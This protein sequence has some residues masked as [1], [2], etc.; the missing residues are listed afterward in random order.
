M[1]DALSEFSDSYWRAAL[2]D[3]GRTWPFDRLSPCV[4]GF[5]DPAR[6]ARIAKARLKYAPYDLLTERPLLL[7]KLTRRGKDD[8]V[9]ALGFIGFLV[10]SRTRYIL[11]TNKNLYCEGHHAVSLAECRGLG[12]RS[13]SA[14]H[15]QSVTLSFPDNTVE[16]ELADVIAGSNI[17][18]E[19]F[20]FTDFLHRILEKR[21]DAPAGEMTAL[22]HPW[23]GNRFVDELKKLGVIHK[24]LV[25]ASRPAFADERII[26]RLADFIV[27]NRRVLFKDGHWLLSGDA[28]FT[29]RD[30]YEGASPAHAH[31]IHSH[32]PVLNVLSVPAAILASKYNEEQAR[33][34]PP[35]PAGYQV[36]FSVGPVTAASAHL[37]RWR[38][39]DVPPFIEAA[40][41]S[42][43]A[44]EDQRGQAADGAG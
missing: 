33:K 41:R 15:R 34:A 19:T 35:R 14:A 37:D 36:T 40:R 27:S 32:N 25:A 8:L 6:D 12:V 21:F 7:A 26:A 10:S 5:P 28:R 16:A 31:P 1:A 3:G 24:T 18:Q 9:L 43:I 39:R 29:I 13:N 23:R 22:I 38:S 44:V 4:P 30:W 17:G 42:G 20:V 2:G 11:V